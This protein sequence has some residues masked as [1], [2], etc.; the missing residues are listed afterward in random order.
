MVKARQETKEPSSYLATLHSLFRN[1]DCYLFCN[2]SLAI[3]YHHSSFVP[4]VLMLSHVLAFCLPCIVS[5]HLVCSLPGSHFLRI[6]CAERTLGFCFAISQNILSSLD[7]WM[8]TQLTIRV[9][10]CFPLV[11]E[12]GK[13]FSLTIRLLSELHMGPQVRV[14]AEG[15]PHQSLSISLNTSWAPYNL[16]Q[17]WHFLPGV[18]PGPWAKDSAPQGCPSSDATPRD[19]G[20]W[21][22]PCLSNLAP[23]WIISCVTQ[24]RH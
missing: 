12:G 21:L 14:G 10:Q 19:Q 13:R 11:T 4:G 3:F 1:I 7:Q 18:S 6:S 5:L 23:N 20:P 17:V 8:E 24:A 22:P 16:I 9:I 2:W 15:F